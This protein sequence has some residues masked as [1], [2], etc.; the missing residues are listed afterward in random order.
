MS[1]AVKFREL[2]GS[3]LAGAS[4][5]TAKF[6]TSG[7]KCL[8]VQAAIA[9]TISAG[10]VQLQHSNDGSTWGNNGTATNVTAAGS[11]FINVADFGYDFAR[12]VIAATT[13]NA[14]D[15]DVLIVAKE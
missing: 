15:I 13:G 6:D 3:A 9:G 14:T 1:C 8:G 4:Y 10:T 2:N 12:V 7:R 11:T 5:T